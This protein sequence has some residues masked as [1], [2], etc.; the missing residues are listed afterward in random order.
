[1]KKEVTGNAAALKLV[2]N[3][4]KAP[5]TPLGQAT[6]NK[7]LKPA[8]GY[9]FEAPINTGDT[10][11]ANKFVKPGKQGGTKGAVTVAKESVT[12]GMGGKFKKGTI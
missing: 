5:K 7:T 6:A 12:S 4:L 9:M 3:G 8:K 10:S 11:F 1:M 2:D